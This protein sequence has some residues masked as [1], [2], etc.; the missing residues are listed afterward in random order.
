MANQTKHL[1]LGDEM[2]L[3]TR[4]EKRTREKTLKTIYTFQCDVCTKQFETNING[5]V[6]A[7]QK[8]HYCSQ[9]CVKSALKKGG[10]AQN[11]MRETCLEKYGSETIY[12]HMNKTRN[13]E[14]AHSES[15]H[16]KRISTMIKKYGFKT[17]R[18]DHSKIELDLIEA[19]SE[20]E[21]SSGY[22]GRNQIDLLCRKKK[23]AV[24]VQGDFWHA[25]PKK[26]T[27]DWINPVTKQ[28]AKEIREK[29]ERKKQ[30]LELKGYAVLYVWENDYRKN[31]ELVI[32]NLRSDILK[33]SI[34]P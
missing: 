27:D 33:L 5:K 6:R 21:F 4:Q 17:F 25:N 15:A 7:K 8:N 29:D 30:F 31:R 34:T 22:I 10:I 2:L 20:F 13:R 24:E 9:D 32:E 28:T 16:K 3:T 18:K 11:N 1:N 19:L 23:I 26:Y 14:L 12:E